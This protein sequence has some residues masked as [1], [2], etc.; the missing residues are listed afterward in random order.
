MSEAGADWEPR[1]QR[2]GKGQEKLLFMSVLPSP[3]IGVGHT[4]A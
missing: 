3:F 2:G 4:T 1:R